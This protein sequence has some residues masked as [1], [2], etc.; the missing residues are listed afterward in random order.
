MKHIIEEFQRVAMAHPSVG[1]SL[2][3]N[4]HELFHL[5]A[6]NVKQRIVGMF[7]KGYDGKLVQV[8]EQVD[9][10]TCG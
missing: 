1:F 5:K 9:F 10:S 7:G 2:H 4:E 6:G 3:H 8:E